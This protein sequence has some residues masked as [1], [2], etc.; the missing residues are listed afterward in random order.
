MGMRQVSGF[1]ALMLRGEEREKERSS[2]ITQIWMLPM[3][4]VLISQILYIKLPC[5]SCAML[6]I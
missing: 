5:C 6:H 2:V 1:P 3:Y 4:T